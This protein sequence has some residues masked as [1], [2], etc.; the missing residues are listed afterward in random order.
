MDM[1][2]REFLATV[3]ALAMAGPLLAA[4]APVASTAPVA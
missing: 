4:D 1:T 2:R 3:P